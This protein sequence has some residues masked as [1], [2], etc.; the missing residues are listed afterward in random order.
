MSQPSQP[1]PRSDERI[2]LRQILSNAITGALGTLITLATLAVVG[3]VIGF[4][5][6]DLPSWFHTLNSGWLLTACVAAV[7]V[8]IGF[9]AGGGYTA[10]AS[11]YVLELIWKSALHQPKPRRAWWLAPIDLLAV[12][13]VWLAFVIIGLRSSISEGI[14]RSSAR[15]EARK[16]SPAAENEQLRAEVERL[17]AEIEQLR[18]KEAET[19]K[20]HVEE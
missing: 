1:D 20:R 9:I 6:G 11:L 15:P 18:A 13:G 3:G 12:I 14:K 4:L 8:V 7:L 19:A 2:S 17:H 10:V 16:P 5:R